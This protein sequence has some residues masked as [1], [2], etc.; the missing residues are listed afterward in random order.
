MKVIISISIDSGRSSQQDH[1]DTQK[2]FHP[3]ILKD[4]VYFYKI[5][6]DLLTY[7]VR[8]LL[9]NWLPIWKF[10]TVNSDKE[11][12]SHLSTEFQEFFNQINNGNALLGWHF[13]K[14]DKKAK[15]AKIHD[16]FTF[17][18]SIMKCISKLNF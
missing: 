13:D 11:Q 17:S 18:F 7:V 4:K 9:L 6:D 16:D 15:E 1:C 5:L 12:I 2:I 3:G 14:A 10:S 8:S